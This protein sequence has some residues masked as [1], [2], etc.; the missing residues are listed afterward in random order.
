M[1]DKGTDFYGKILVVQSPIYLDR[2]GKKN[3]EHQ[4]NIVMFDDIFA[5]Y[6]AGLYTIRSIARKKDDVDILKSKSQDI[7]LSWLM[8]TPTDDV[9]MLAER[10][11][12]EEQLKKYNSFWEKKI[13]T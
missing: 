4:K 12:I 3:P 1:M 2:E 9:K 11:K 7:A 8:K 13:L 5:L 10:D 6:R